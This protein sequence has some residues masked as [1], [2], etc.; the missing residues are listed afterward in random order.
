M[1]PDKIQKIDNK[2]STNIF[3][4]GEPGVGK[5]VLAA[6]SPKAL[7][8]VPNTD[9]TVS[10]RGTG[11]DMWVVS[12]YLD[13]AE[14]HE[15]LLHGGSKEYDWVWFDNVSIWQDYNM[16]AI[17][18][19]TVDRKTTR[20]F[21][22]PDRP[23]YLRNQNQLSFFIRN[24]VALPVNFGMVAHVMKEYSALTDDE[25]L[26][27]LIQGGRGALSQKLSGMMNIVG[28]MIARS[29]N[30]GTQRILYTSKSRRY[31][32]RDRFGV[33]PSKMVNPTI[34]QIQDMVSK[35]QTPKTTRKRRS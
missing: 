12:N 13:L 26:M 31:V 22:I 3:L 7:F 1:K 10:M 24:M 27:P 19:E 29:T 20:E 23:E 21:F 11:S 18:T 14:V 16:D 5:S 9:E 34:V 15:Y 30:K 4:Y 35:T 6:T 25:M 33:L 8:L 28:Y 17:M 2:G 32:A